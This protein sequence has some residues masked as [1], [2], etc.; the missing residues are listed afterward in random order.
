[1]NSKKLFGTKS[2]S[3]ISTNLNHSRI[4]NMR[5]FMPTVSKF[6]SIVETKAFYGIFLL[7]AIGLFLILEI[8]FFFLCLPSV[9][10]KYVL[11]MWC[12][13]SSG[14]ILVLVS[15]LPTMCS[16]FAVPWHLVHPHLV[17]RTILTHIFSPSDIWTLEL[18]THIF[19]VPLT[20]SPRTFRPPLE[21][22]G[23][24]ATCDN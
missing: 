17:L 3:H 10:L 6:G 23:Q 20:F 24:I 12:W 11:F 4:K 13:L 15:F 9:D 19:F 1:M 22:D 14:Y 21:A 8:I 2:F 16:V 5:S 7:F 18:L